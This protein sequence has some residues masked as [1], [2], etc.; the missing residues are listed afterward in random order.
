MDKRV[1]NKPA[2]YKPIP[3][4]GINI[5]TYKNYPHYQ[6]HESKLQSVSNQPIYRYAKNYKSGKTS[7]C[8]C[9][10]SNDSDTK[11]VETFLDYQA[12]HLSTNVKE[13]IKGGSKGL[14]GIE[15][16]YLT[17]SYKASV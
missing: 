5:A 7:Y 8:L 9:M 2:V 11:A 17:D 3:V 12:G 1:L 4:D 13:A 10:I 16:M 15:F 14:F 6:A